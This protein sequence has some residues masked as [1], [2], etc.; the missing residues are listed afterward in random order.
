MIPKKYSLEFLISYLLCI[1]EVTTMAAVIGFVLASLSI[2]IV[3]ASTLSNPSLI[4]PSS[5]KA[6]A[7]SSNYIHRCDGTAFGH[8]LDTISCVEALSQIDVSST[9]QQT[10]GARFSGPYDV[11]LPKRYINCSVSH[12]S[13]CVRESSPVN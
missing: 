12:P 3:S 2:L 10:Y 9:T 6:N 4:L 8:D 1:I 11:K 13:S 5:A 7:T